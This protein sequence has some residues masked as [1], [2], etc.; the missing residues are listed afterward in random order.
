MS[1]KVVD[2]HGR[3]VPSVPGWYWA[4]HK[5]VGW[6]ITNL[7]IVDG[8][9]YVMDAGPTGW[10]VL[11]DQFLEWDDQCIPNREDSLA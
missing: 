7:Q 4:R 11:I 5:V 8:R 9:P 6:V 1:K 3:T 2:A 10:N